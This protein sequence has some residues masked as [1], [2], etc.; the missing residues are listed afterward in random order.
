LSDMK[1]SG[2]LPDFYIDLKQRPLF[3]AFDDKF[4][5]TAG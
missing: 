5:H 1:I 4:S 3:R 2:K